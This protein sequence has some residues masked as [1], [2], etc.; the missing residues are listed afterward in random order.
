MARDPRADIL[1]DDPFAPTYRHKVHRVH[2][3]QGEGNTIHIDLNQMKAPT[4]SDLYSGF[5]GFNMEAEPM[6]SSDSMLKFSRIEIKHLAQAA[7]VLSLEMGFVHL[8]GLML[9]SKLGFSTWLSQFIVVCFIALLSISPSLILHE[10]GHKF[11]AQKYGCW[12]E[13][14]A[15]PKGLRFGLILSIFL[16]II[17][18]APGAVMVMGRINNKEN[19]HIALAGPAVNFF[20]A[21]MGIPLWAFILMAT[22][23]FETQIPVLTT[24]GML[25]YFYEGSFVWQAFLISCAVYWI[26]M[27]FIIGLFNMLP[28]GPLDGKKIK[29]W[30][31]NIF[32]VAIA[33]FAIPTAGLILG[34]WNPLN[35]LISIAGMF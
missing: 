19:G 26:Q 6:S 11:M 5:F 27:N 23:A 32:W 14:R 9:G 34:M 3:R 13:F 1:D 8:G 4:L 7:L 30:N 21:I 20:L 15:D 17:F 10:L 25:S 22:G 33:L 24:T 18:F 31:E 29:N 16:G 28:F 12:A 2:A 35:L